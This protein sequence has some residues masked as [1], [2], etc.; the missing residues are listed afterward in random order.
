ME[1]NFFFNLFLQAEISKMTIL[2]R[3]VLGVVE[4]LLMSWGALG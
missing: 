4:E 1:G 2:F 3:C